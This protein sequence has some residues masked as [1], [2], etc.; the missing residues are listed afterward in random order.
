MMDT[1][2]QLL[3]KWNKVY[4][5]TAIR[6][7]KDMMTLHIQDSLSIGPYLHG[8]RIIDVGT[9]AGLPG[10]P[11]AIT[12][13]DKHF[14]L[15]DSN[16]KKTRFL[17]HV[18]HTLGLKNVTVVHSRVEKFR[19]TEGFDSILSR[20]FAS[21]SDMLAMTDHLCAI[22]GR[23]LAMK[24]QYTETELPAHI[25]LIG[26]YPLHVPGLDAQRNLVILEK[27]ADA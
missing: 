9:G 11:L 1:Y 5:L 18:Q 24:G 23:F 27:N 25:R 19:P 16:G 10:I 20:A 2:L 26:V 12:Y 7:P 8:S 15:L 22:G 17:T 6:D 4:N 13:P 3:E 21:L 14:T